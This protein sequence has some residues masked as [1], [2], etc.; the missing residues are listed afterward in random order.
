MN[1]RRVRAGGVEEGRVRR[2]AP[3]PG[4]SVGWS[5]E[6]AQKLAAL[7]DQAYDGIV[8]FGVVRTGSR[9]VAEDVAAAAFA[10]AARAFAGGATVD[11]AWLYMVVRRR[12][13][14][15]WRRSERQRRRVQRLGEWHHVQSQATSSDDPAPDQV[16]R[17]LDSL[18]ERHRALLT[19]RYLDDHSVTEIAEVVGLTYSAAESA[20]A[21]ARRSFIAAW[22][23]GT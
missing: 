5:D 14:D 19:L 12:M 10:D 8:R 21:R 11:E 13:I 1:A 16:R 20:L 22:E 15:H 17:A 3:D 18:P 7:F 4:C 9:S 23:E 2:A 6:T